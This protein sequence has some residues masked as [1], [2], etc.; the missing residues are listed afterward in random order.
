M[1]MPGWWKPYAVADRDAV[2]GNA[3]EAYFSFRFRYRGK[4]YEPIVTIIISTLTGK[5]RKQYYEDSPVVF[6]C[7]GNGLSYGY[8]LPGELPDAFLRP[9]HM[10]YDYVKY[11]RP[12]RLL[13]KMVKD[14]PRV[15]RT[16]RCG[17]RTRGCRS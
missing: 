14:A 1:L 2:Q 12:I 16:F 9:D 8:I 6:L 13:K 3:R 10:D 15:M 7:E 11:G 4:T 17:C 5:A